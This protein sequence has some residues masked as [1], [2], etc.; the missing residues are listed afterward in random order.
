[1]AVQT[2]TKEA[3]EITLNVNDHIKENVNNNI[4][5]TN[6]MVTAV[7]EEEKYKN[8]RDFYC[9]Y[10]CSTKFQLHVHEAEDLSIY[11]GIQMD[12]IEE[13]KTNKFIKLFPCVE[14]KSKSK[15]IDKHMKH[16]DSYHGEI[17]YSLNCLF[18]DCEFNTNIP[19]DL[20]K[21]FGQ[22]HEN[23]VTKTMMEKRKTTI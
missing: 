15:G 17:D 14:C 16:F 1:M 21:H 18:N 11:K 22:K 13:D 3:D 4:D 10:F 5:Q 9:K 12:E 7:T 2:H 23:S 20:M 8:G 19:S 6:D